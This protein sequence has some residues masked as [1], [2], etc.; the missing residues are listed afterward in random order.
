MGDEEVGGAVEQRLERRS[1][2]VDRQEGHLDP[3]R[4]GQGQPRDVGDGADGLDGE[5]KVAGVF[6]GVGHEV[7]QRFELGILAD[8]DGGGGRVGETD[9]FEAVDRV[10]QLAQVGLGGQ[11]ADRGHGDG[12]P[13]GPGAGGLGHADGAPCPGG[14]LDHHVGAEGIGHLLLHGAGG[15]VGAAAGRER[16]DDGNRLCRRGAG[17]EQRGGDCA[18]C[19]CSGCEFPESHGFLLNL[20]NDAALPP[21]VTQNR[22]TQ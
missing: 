14:V 7:F 4:V 6:L 2:A 1:V 10:G 18:G 8:R 20:V 5:G 15:D 21:V 17:L 12:A 3:R 22:A 19:E 16:H 11:R 13:V 9:I